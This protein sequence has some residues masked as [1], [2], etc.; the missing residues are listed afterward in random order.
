[1]RQNLRRV[2]NRT[3][4]ACSRVKLPLVE[5]MTR[6]FNHAWDLML[7]AITL[8]ALATLAKAESE[9]K[10][11][12]T[13]DACVTAAMTDY[14]KTNDALVQQTATVMSVEAT[15]A[16]R[17][18]QEEYCLRFVRCSLDDQNSAIFGVQFDSCLK[19]EALEKYDAIPAD[20][21]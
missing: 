20:T 5:K 7:M 4:V 3:K 15:I 21:D 10:K 9:S 6:R 16:Q 8:S 1:M 2:G 17:R 19:D 14:V 13:E 18:L 12:R 11:E